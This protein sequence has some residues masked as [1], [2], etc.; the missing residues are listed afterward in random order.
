M[1]KRL[2]LS[3]VLFLVTGNAV[4]QQAMLEWR[5][6]LPYSEFIEV[7]ATDEWVFAATPYA[8]V[9]YDKSENFAERINTINALSDFGISAMNYDPISQWVIIGYE[10]GNI[11]LIRDQ[12]TYNLPAIKNSN[13]SGSKRVNHIEVKDSLAYICTDFGVVE[14]DINA[15][16]FKDAYYPEQNNI[17]IY[18]IAFWND[19]I[20]LA[21]SN[22][23]FRAN[24]NN[25][26]LIDNNSWSPF[27][28]PFALGDTCRVSEIEVFQD[29]LY[30]IEDQES[31]SKDSLWRHTGS[32]W[33]LVSSYA[34]VNLNR[35]K[36]KDDKFLISLV[37]NARVVDANFNELENIFQY[38]FGA[39]EINSFD[40]DRENM[41]WLADKY[42]GLV[43][44][45][46]SFSSQRVAPEG[47][48]FPGSY[49]LDYSNGRIGV[50]GGALT[51]NF[52]NVFRTDGFYVFEN[53]E[54]VSYN[55]FNSAIL[56]DSV[57]DYTG[58]A[59]DPVDPN[60]YFV[61]SFSQKPLFKIENGAIAELYNKNNS[62]LQDQSN[63][64]GL[65][66]M[67]DMQVDDNQT[68][69]I[70][71]GKVEEPLVAMDINENW[72][73][74]S[75]GS[76]AVNRTT[77]RLYIDFFKNKWVAVRG[78][79]LIAFNENGTMSDLTDDEIA[80]FTDSEGSG[81]LPSAVVTDMEMDFNN[82]LWVT[83]DNGLAVIYNVEQVFDPEADVE[84]QRILI[85][86]GVN[87][88]ALLGGVD[89][90]AIDVDGAN[91]KWIAT[92]SSGVFCLSPDGTEE[93]YRFTSENSPLFTNAVLDVRVNHATG[94]VF[95]ATE[96]GLLSFRAD[97]TYGDFE[98]SN[99]TVFPNPVRPEFEGPITIQGIAFDSDVKIMDPA[100]RMVFQATS[101]GGTVV[102]DGKL[103]DGTRASSG[104]YV[105]LVGEKQNKGKAKT[106]ILFLN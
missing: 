97:A 55:A 70:A 101:N 28:L 106:K 76:Q 104:V 54:W 71:N 81:N 50:A 56:A 22:G 2:F 13:V 64:P 11:D 46:N 105:V 10:N 59:F 47:P 84:A 68:L 38:S 14:L 83:T 91:R 26:F 31:F 100:G 85:D 5:E 53:E 93:V 19:S 82:Q 63:N 36:S 52:A 27:S 57:Y 23:L 25:A 15:F 7:V 6:H 61:C 79:G 4:G 58:I 9:R 48:F 29:Q 44:A 39:M 24:E 43:E 34:E 37:Y 66:N 51:A 1:S 98:F 69:W 92:A 72:H 42:N 88:E 96:N 74:F 95:F 33:E 89:I 103:P 40:V 73:A 87:V 20:Y 90:T 16:E 99:V 77:Q 3:I 67:H 30:A 17:E 102:W 62:S 21:S 8:L 35:L 75:L 18:D 80:Y 12:Q 41:Y 45:P 78:F 94:E 65:Y 60:R 86:D 32:S 49:K